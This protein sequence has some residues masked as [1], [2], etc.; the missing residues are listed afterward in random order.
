M[1]QPE[2]K[3][4]VTFPSEERTK[5]KDILSTEGWDKSATDTLRRP[6]PP[7]YRVL[8]NKPKVVH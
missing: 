2:Q 7:V 1:M 3:T 4:T 5:E 8:K 6:T